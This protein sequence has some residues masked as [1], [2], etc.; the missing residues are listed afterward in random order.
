[1][2]L[3]KLEWDEAKNRANLRKHGLDFVDAREMFRGG[4]FYELDTREDYGRWT[5]LGM[6]RG[7]IAHVV[8]VERGAETIRVISLRKA[9]RRECKEYEKAIRDRLEA[10]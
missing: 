6:I 10:G 5:G 1:M 7:R 9:S 4:F 3:D 2:I 8:F